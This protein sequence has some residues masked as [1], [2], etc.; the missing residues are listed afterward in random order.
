MD[1]L[2]ARMPDAERRAVLDHAIAS[3]ALN[4]Y[5]VES[6]T[7][8]QVVV[9]KR[10]RV[11]FWSNFGLVVITGGFWLAVL[12]IRLLNWPVDRVVLTVDVNGRLLGDFS[13]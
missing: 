3:Y 9:G 5:R 13:S 1:D 7:G 10:Q 11:H 12:A 8:W 4:G 2:R 6:D